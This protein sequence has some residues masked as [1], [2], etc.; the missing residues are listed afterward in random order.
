M[1]ARASIRPTGRFWRQFLAL[2]AIVLLGFALRLYHLDYQSLW[3]DEAFTV[4]MG[5][6]PL[7][8]MTDAIA[9]EGLETGTL[10]HPPLHYVLLHTW[11]KLFGVGA[12]QARLLFMIFGVLAIPV[13][14]LLAR[15]LFDHRTGL[16]SALLLAVSQLGVMYSQETRPYALLLFF[17]LCSVCLFVITLRYRRALAWWGFVLCVAL[18]LYTHYYSIFIIL[19]LLVFVAIYRRKYALPAGWLVGGLALVVAAFIP[20]LMSGIITQA[21]QSN[22]L[23]HDQAAY[24]AISVSSPIKAINAFNNG[25]LTGLL[26]ASP[27]WTYLVGGL[28]FSVPALLAWIDATNKPGTD[29]RESL[30]LLALLCALPLV[31]ILAVAALFNIQYDVR[32]VLFCAAPYYILVA[33]GLF[34]LTSARLRLAVVALIL[35]YSAV[36]LRANY[37][38][39]YKENYRDA[40]AFL[41]QEYREG[42][43]AMFLPFE[44]VPRQWSIYQGDDATLRVASLDTAASAATPCDALWV[45]TYRRIGWAVEQDEA[46]ERKLQAFYSKV[47]EERF[48]WVHVSLYTP[49]DQVSHS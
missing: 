34:N 29:Y 37:F 2:F 46:G 9:E 27:W 20:W 32:Y 18:M 36:A 47:R 40:L 6:Q 23:F 1:C 7:S 11:F 49:K 43:C 48:F 26:D 21:L 8:G 42:D 13:L 25:K 19:P 41:A 12:Y 16:L 24:F 30:W 3:Y 4:W 45:V 31:A 17:A 15:L 14:Y 44:D 10:D 33:R 39:P 22:A 28:L 38:M 5:T 35:L